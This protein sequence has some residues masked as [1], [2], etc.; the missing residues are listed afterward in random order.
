MSTTF[1]GLMTAIITPFHKNLELDFEAFRRILS[2]QKNSGVD[3]IVVGGTTGE[4]PT[5]SLDELEQCLDVALEYQDE[6][7]HIYAGTGT[8]D[9]KKTL[10]KSE[11]FAQK[12]FSGGR[13]INGVMLVCPYYN[14]PSQRHMELYF[15]E[16][17]QKLKET[18]VCLYNVPGRT[19]VSLKPETFAQ[20][21]ARH[22]NVVAIKEASGD[23]L[24]YAQHKMLWKKLGFRH[25]NLLS[26]NDAELL[27]S[28]AFGGD[29]VISVT[30]HIIAPTLKK[31]IT[32]LGKQDLNTA[33]DL[34]IKVHDF[35]VGL[36][37]QPN[38]TGVKFLLSHLG[39]CCPDLR[40]PL[41]E[42]TDTEA[43]FFKNQLAELER[44]EIPVLR[45]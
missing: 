15:G 2:A 21:A 18:A 31:I 26:G 37:A 22:E 14:K 30:A 4:S 38:P 40:A 24:S 12:N 41:Y 20:I 23:V 33:Q 36:F 5:L 16:L 44:L 43:L 9:Y 28:L 7:F 34:A 3:G 17:C 13:K 27:P 1:H 11:Y 19:G 29:G 45:A 25:I 42:L 39:F 35:Q 6:K 32:S 8:N 10:E